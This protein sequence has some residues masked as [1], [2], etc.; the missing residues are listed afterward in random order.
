M[1]Q[2]LQIGPVCRGLLICQHSPTINDCAIKNKLTIRKP[3]DDRD[4][5]IDLNAFRPALGAQREQACT[6]G[7]GGRF[8]NASC[9]KFPDFMD[10]GIERRRPLLRATLPSEGR[11]LPE[12]RTM[13]ERDAFKE[14]KPP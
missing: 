9:Q 1:E 2:E 6:S 13:T 10:L 5:Q 4:S 8:S 12:S 11:V 14:H 7:W 3:Y